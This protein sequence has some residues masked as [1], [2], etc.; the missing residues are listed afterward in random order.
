[1]TQLQQKMT[2]PAAMAQKLDVVRRRT[3]RVRISTAIVAAAAVLLAAM[4]VAMIVDWLATIY[5]VRWRALLTYTAWAT[6]GV[7]LGAWAVAAWRHT[8]RVDQMAAKVDREIPELEERWS[9]VTE[10]TTGGNS[11]EV[12]PAM[13]QQ[14]SSEAQRWTPKI[15]ADRV[16][17]L[18]GLI[19][20][21]LFLT[22]ITTVLG[23]A[24]V[25]D[26]QRTTVLLQR[27]WQPYT[28]ISATELADL[29]GDLV[30]GRGESVVLN[31]NLVGAPVTQASLL[32]QPNAG[33]EKSIT[34]TPRGEAQDH[35]THRLRSV[36]EPLRYRMRAGDGQTPWFEIIVADRPQLGKVKLKLTPPAY[37]RKEP[38]VINKLPRRVTV[39]EGSRVEI[40]LKPKQTLRSFHLRLGP[41][42]TEQL[43][44]NEQGW[45]R[46][47]T[48]LN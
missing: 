18:D 27:F 4:A 3:L 26:S 48:T 14:V 41:D 15:Q 44:A 34:L 2:L 40:A 19:R 42:L 43:T 22:A 20:A 17:P 37:T 38:K 28:A 7:T 6:A 5:D 25:L 45:Y 9:T 1:M 16:V 10:V 32:L 30:V 39:L 31:A 13:F 21:L 8:R 47:E 23:L 46:W 36:K 35:V 11:S 12:H 29:P 33:E 24:V